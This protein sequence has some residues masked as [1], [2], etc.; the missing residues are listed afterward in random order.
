MLHLDEGTI[1]AW[2]DGE[3]PPDEAEEAARHVASCAACGALVAEARGLMAGATRIVSALDAGPAGVVARGDVRATTRPRGYRFAITPA[4]MS[5]AAT[6]VVAVGITLSVRHASRDAAVPTAAKT[7]VDSPAAAAAPRI[8]AQR[9]A[10]AD[11]ISSPPASPAPQALKAKRATV[12][13]LASAEN[14]APVS[15]KP[16][17]AQAPAAGILPIVEQKALSVSRQTAADAAKQVASAAPVAEAAPAPRRLD[18]TRAKDE[19]AKVAVDSISRAPAPP[20]RRAVSVSAVNQLAEVVTTSDRDAGS[21]GGVTFP[22][23]YR[24]V[25]D[26][27]DWRGRIPASFALERLATI[28]GAAGQGSAAGAAGPRPSAAP[29]QANR[30]IAFAPSGNPV[31][32]ILPNGRVD[33][34]VVGQWAANSGLINVQFRADPRRPVTLQLMNASSTAHVIS[35]DR[36]DSV[37]IVRM[38][39]PR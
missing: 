6:I 23:C 39:C 19:M 33:S 36:T 1:H 22:S 12:S 17:G 2:L 8:A 30:V 25:V 37:R 24:V 14:N 13:K 9:V 16:A 35:N 29:V 15:G 5:I 3:L 18:S 21:I 20:A 31:H 11:S 4:R 27:T 32:A 10:A 38:T 34:L 7:T 28:A 26:S